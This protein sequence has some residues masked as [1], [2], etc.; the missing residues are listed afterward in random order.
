METIHAVELTYY[1][2]ILTRENVKVQEQALQLA[3]RLVADNKKRVQVEAL[4]ELDAKQSQSQLEVRR[5][6]LLAAQRNVLLQENSLKSLLAGEYEA[7]KDTTIVPTETL[8]A[9]P[10]DFDVEESWERGLARRPDVQQ[11]RLIVE[12]LGLIGKFNYNQL[13]PQLDLVGS[14]GQSGL[15]R[16]YS[17]AMAGMRDGDFP[18]YSYGAVVTLPLTMRGARSNYKINRAE[19]KRAKLTAQGVEHQVMRD[20]EDAIRVAET[21]LQR[22]G[23]TRSATLFAQEALEGEQ[24][25]LDSGK[26]TTFVVLQLQRDLTAARSAEVQ[27]LAD[28]NRALAQLAL[29]EGATL[30]RHKV[31]LEIE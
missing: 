30:E 26:T 8:L 5:S 13:F 29:Q 11:A 7:W 4:A 18:S 10:R 28:Y 6:D 24:K 23:T 19:Q 25:K 1:S 14:Y 22:V 17:G 2:L 12:D 9:V 16:G 27:A 21:S 20:I 15:G 31:N 3:D